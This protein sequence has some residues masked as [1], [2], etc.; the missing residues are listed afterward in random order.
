MR[1]IKSE[2][3]EKKFKNSLDSF[4]EKWAEMYNIED[5]TKMS[6]KKVNKISENLKRRI[7]MDYIKFRIDE[8]F[9]YYLNLYKLYEM[10]CIYFEVHNKFMEKYKVTP[11]DTETIQEKLGYEVAFSETVKR[12]VKDLTHWF[13]S[14][15]EIIKKEFVV[16]PRDNNFL[17]NNIEK[18]IKTSKLNFFSENENI[19]EKEKEFL[20][21]ILIRLEYSRRNID[22]IYGHWKEGEDKKLRTMIKSSLTKVENTINLVLE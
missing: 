8:K 2:R 22:V 1:K 6:N 19:N 15:L 11:D 9:M 18:I 4:Y 17:Y 21:N 16:I 10:V 7:D 20:N 14:T 5:Y 13:A 3:K 12:K